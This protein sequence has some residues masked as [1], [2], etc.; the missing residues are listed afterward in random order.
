MANIPQAEDMVKAWTETQ[1]KLW[2]T[3]LETLQNSPQSTTTKVWQEGIGKWQE[4]L[5]STI[6]S[7]L[8]AMRKWAENVQEFASAPAE[9]RKWADEGVQMLERWTGAQRQLWELWFEFL[10]K[11]D[12][13]I[14]KE[15]GKENLEQFVKSWQDMTKQIMALQQDWASS[16]SKGRG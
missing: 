2:N 4:S 12:A 7:Q 3:W 14:S 11:T 10:R 1:Q 5:D 8:D 13:G 6:D 9:T 16:W 15:G